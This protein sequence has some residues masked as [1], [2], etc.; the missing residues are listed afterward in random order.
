VSRR[1][2]VEDLLRFVTLSDPRISPDG[3]QVAYVAETLDLDANQTRSAIW[4]V[5]CQGGLARQLTAGARHDTAP[6][7]S[8]DGRTLAFLSD[9]DGAR[10]LYLLS[11]AGGDPRRLT[12]HPVGVADPR[13]APDGARLLFLADGADRRGEPVPVAEKDGRRR[14]TTIRQ[15]RHKLDGQ[16]F[17]GPARRHVWVVGLDG[18]AEQVTDGPCEDAAAA[19]SPDGREIA[20]S[21]DRSAE[22]DQHYEGGA[23]HVVDV[24]TGVLRRLTP[25]S[26]RATVPAWSPDGASIAYVG[27]ET[28]DDA[29]PSQLHLFVVPAAGGQ[30][31]SLTGELGR[32]VGQRPGGYLTPS[33]PVW[34]GDGEL[35][36]LIGSGGETHLW[37]V[38]P[39]Q[40]T[41]GAH[42]TL[43]FSADDARQRF[44]LTIADPAAPPE[45]HV[46]DAAGG[47]HRLTA[48]NAALLDELDL[49]RPE[50]LTFERD[51]LEVEGWLLR[52]PPAPDPQPPP[53]IP[54]IVS[55]HGGPHNYFGQTWNL[56]HQLYAAHGWAV[57]YVNPR[58]S[59]GYGEPFAQAVIADWGGGDLADQL[60]A[61][62]LVL[63]RSEPAIDP[64]RLAM[65]G[66]S[67]GGF[68][69]CWAITRT[70]RFRVGVAG[71]CI[72]NLISF[73]GTSDLG[74]TWGEREFGGPPSAR[75]DW[76]LERS[77]VLHA[78]RI[79]TPLLLYHG[80]DD[81]RCPIE[82]SEQMFTALRALG[83]EVEL[84]RL[85]G[86]THGA[87]SGAPVHRVEARRAILAY[88]ARR[89]A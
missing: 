50:R 65:T 1:L 89:L 56:D 14:L 62:D 68:M 59:G 35:R 33:P 45:V 58:G 17:F 10:Q 26:G 61:V 22:R 44:A 54:L 71:A 42:A 70:N 21:S 76:Y 77:A 39:R 64:A 73:Y 9:R 40:L 78:E 74:A 60:A 15:H 46:W 37:A 85:P 48:A 83:K 6:R 32:S 11:L 72:A 51:G 66:S 57:L 20:F 38:P 8:P 53:P 30:P 25:E 13:W 43:E 29:G 63:S 3:C 31:R 55:V 2:T 28:A 86:E 82:Q 75:L 69:T 80:E 24:A 5:D 67:Y 47:L 88:L 27:G 19:W 12:D 49:P 52:P 7:W 16:G 81:L 18:A 84:L 87:L 36:Y 41:A 23:I 4:L 34:T 79:S